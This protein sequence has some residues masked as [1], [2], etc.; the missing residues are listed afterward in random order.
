MFVTH[1]MRAHSVSLS[2]C[3]FACMSVASV[4]GADDAKR[5][6]VTAST[7]GQTLRKEDKLLEAREKFHACAEDP[8]PD[9]VKSR[10]TRW[11]SEIEAEIPSVIV[12]AKDAGGADVLDI[13]VTIDGRATQVGRQEPL[14]PG[15]HV[16]IVKR[17][18]GQSKEERFLLVDGERAR[19]LTV[20]LADAAPD[21]S[22]ASHPAA[23]SS[24]SAPAAGSSAPETAHGSVVPAGGWVLGAISLLALGST[25]L[26]YAEAASD[27]SGLQHGCSPS[28]TDSDT[29]PFRTHLTIAY[30]SLGVGIAAAV[31]A[32]TWTLVSQPSKPTK[33]AAYVPVVNV[34]PIAGGA[35]TTIGLSF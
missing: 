24:A 30:V 12:R 6:C 10:C 5:A 14:D 16:V 23:S 31:G 1:R 11:L 35:L 25:A 20:H 34:L 33:A 3:V 29:Q 18:G 7:D 17:P 22:A 8:C 15:E 21:P 32:V 9:V 28:C 2:A 27:F 4:A 19:V 26:F 13:D